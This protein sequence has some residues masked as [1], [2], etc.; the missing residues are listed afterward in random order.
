M[1]NLNLSNKPLWGKYLQGWWS[2][3]PDALQ[4]FCACLSNIICGC[5]EYHNK[6]FTLL[7]FMILYQTHIKWRHLKQFFCGFNWT[8][9]FYRHTHIQSGILHQKPGFQRADLMIFDIR[10][11]IWFSM[12]NSPPPLFLNLRIKW[13]YQTKYVKVPILFHFLNTSFY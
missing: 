9:F 11:Q 1:K 7:H 13:I 12:V 4:K 8:N 3:D 5:D 2:M 10:I 6:K